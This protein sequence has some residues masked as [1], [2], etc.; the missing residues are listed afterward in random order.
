MN[1]RHDYTWT[2][3]QVRQASQLTV[4]DIIITPTVSYHYAVDGSGVRQPDGEAMDG[5]AWT[6]EKQDDWTVTCRTPDIPQM[7]GVFAGKSSVLTVR[8][9][10]K[11]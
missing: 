3:M 4:G 11:K 9:D 2:D 5:H 8:P 7:A 10:A 6:V 1:N